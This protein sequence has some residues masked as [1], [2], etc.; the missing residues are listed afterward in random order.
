M[1]ITILGASRFGVAT[2][3]QLIEDNHEVVLI[4]KNESRLDELADGLDCAMVCGDGTVPLTLRDAY[5]DGSDAL[6]A[7]TNEDDVNILAAVVGRSIGFERVIP[8]I[9]RPELVSVADELGL[10]DVI[11]PHESLARSIVEGLTQHSEME[12]DLALHRELRIVNH[13]VTSRLSGCQ[14]KDLDLPENA[15]PVAHS[16]S[17]RETFADPD[18]TLCKGDHVLFVVAADQAEDLNQLFSED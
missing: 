17:E 14:I 9:V 5:G 1:H 7:L 13:T 2:V 12:I 10:D 15:R 8:Q 3:R 18:D 16:G 6:V 11:T 4:D